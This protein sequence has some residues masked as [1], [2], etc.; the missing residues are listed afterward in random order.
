MAPRIVTRIAFVIVRYA[1]HPSL[2]RPERGLALERF[3]FLLGYRDRT[4]TLTLREGYV[5]EEF[6]VLARREAHPGG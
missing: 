2:A 5:T 1:V 4:V 6:I 3:V